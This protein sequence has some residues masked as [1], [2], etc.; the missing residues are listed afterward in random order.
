MFPKRNKKNID[1]EIDEVQNTKEYEV[2]T[3][4][5]G[6][7]ASDF[8]SKIEEQI[9]ILNNFRIKTNDIKKIKITTLE[10]YKPID[11]KS[12]IKKDII[13]TEETKTQI[14][15][16]TG[17]S[18]SSPDDDK[19][20]P[21]LLIVDKTK[22]LKTLQYYRE[23][24]V[25]EIK[26][27]E[28]YYE[29]IKN[30]KFKMNYETGILQDIT[31]NEKNHFQYLGVWSS[32]T[33]SI[34]VGRAF[35]PLLGG[36]LKKFISSLFGTE[37]SMYEFSDKLAKGIPFSNNEFIGGITGINTYVN[38]YFF[39]NATTQALQN[40]NPDYVLRYLAQNGSQKILSMILYNGI[41]FLVG[42]SS[43]PVLLSSV[44]ASTL[45]FL[46][47]IS[48][49]TQSIFVSD[50]AQ[51]GVSMLAQM[52]GTMIIGE[53]MNYRFKELAEYENT[54]KEISKKQLSDKRKRE[55][56]KKMMKFMEEQKHDLI[57]DR[58]IRGEYNLMDKIEEVAKENS[59]LIGFL[60]G[61][62][63]MVLG[64]RQIG[65]FDSEFWNQQVVPS[66]ETIS[67]KLEE[68]LDISGNTFS[69][70]FKAFLIPLV[71]KTLLQQL[72]IREKIQKKV[73][74]II[75]E[76]VIPYLKEFHTI[77][78]ISKWKMFKEI[79]VLRYIL[80]E[81]MKIKSLEYYT[82]EKLFE[83]MTT[84]NITQMVYGEVEK[85]A[86]H[87]I[88][89]IDEDE[90]VGS[91]FGS[92][93]NP[94]T[95]FGATKQDLEG[96]WAEG[97]AS[98]L[99]GASTMI[100]N[101]W[102]NGFNDLDEHT[103]ELGKLKLGVAQF[104]T[105][106]AKFSGTDKELTQQSDLAV[107]QQTAISLWQDGILPT[108]FNL[109]SIKT[110]D[111][112]KNALL[113]KTVSYEQRRKYTYILPLE[114][115][116]IAQVKKLL[117]SYQFLLPEFIKNMIQFQNL[118]ISSEG[119]KRKIN[120]ESLFFGIY[121]ESSLKK[122]YM[123]TDLDSKIQQGKDE[124]QLVNNEYSE[125]L[126][127]IKSWA[128]KLQPFWNN[129][130]NF[131]KNSRVAAAKIKAMDNLKNA[132]DILKKT[133]EPTAIKK[134]EENVR[135]A[136]A[137]MESF[138]DKIYDGTLQ[139]T[140]DD[141]KA[142]QIIWQMSKSILKY[143]LPKSF[144]EIKDFVLNGFY[145][146][147]ILTSLKNMFL[148][149]WRNPSAVK[150]N[151]S[152]QEYLNR[153][154]QVCLKSNLNEYNSCD[155][156]AF[157]KLIQDTKV[158]VINY[159][160]WKKLSDQDKLAFFNTYS[161][162]IQTGDYSFLLTNF[163]EYI[164]PTLL[165]KLIT[166]QNKNIT[167]FPSEAESDQ[168][169]LS[170]YDP[171]SRPVF[172]KA[173]EMGDFSCIGSISSYIDSINDF[174]KNL[175][176][177]G[178]DT[179][180][181]RN[182]MKLYGSVGHKSDPRF[183]SEL[184]EPI[185][186]G[187]KKGNVT[188]VLQSLQ[189]TK[190]FKD[191]DW[192]SI[193]GPQGEEKASLFIE[194]MKY[195]AF[196]HEN[197]LP[198]DLDKLS[199]LSSA[200]KLKAIQLYFKLFNMDKLPEIT[201]NE[202]TSLTEQRTI[203]Q[204]ERN[205]I[206]NQLMGISNGYEALKGVFKENVLLYITQEQ[207]DYDKYY[208][209]FTGT[210][211]KQYKTN[212]NDYRYNGFRK[213][214]E[215]QRDEI[216]RIEKRLNFFAVNYCL[217]NDRDCK[218]NI[219]NPKDISLT[220]HIKLLEKVFDGKLSDNQQK[221]GYIF[222]FRNNK[223]GEKYGVDL[224]KKTTEIINQLDTNGEMNIEQQITYFEKHVGKISSSGK[225]RI[226]YLI[227]LIDTYK[228]K[229]NE[230]VEYLKPFFCTLDNNC[231]QLYDRLNYKFI[232]DIDLNSLITTQLQ[233][234]VSSFERFN[235]VQ[236]DLGTFLLNF[237]GNTIDEL[238]TYEN[239]IA[240][241]N[242]H[243]IEEFQTY[244]QYK[245]LNG[246]DPE[247]IIAT[248]IGKIL[249]FKNKKIE[250]L[251]STLNTLK[252][253]SE[254]TPE[255]LQQIKILETEI[256]NIT[257]ESGLKDLT[258]KLKLLNDKRNYLKNK[259][260]LNDEDNKRL[261]ELDIQVNTIYNEI[262][263]KFGSA[264]KIIKSP[265]IGEKI[266][267]RF[268]YTFEGFVI[269][270]TDEG[271]T[272]ETP[273]IADILSI[274]DQEAS[275]QNIMKDWDITSIDLPDN[276]D[277]LPIS[278]KMTIISNILIEKN[279]FISNLPN[280]IIPCL[281]NTSCQPEL[282]L[283]NKKH[284]VYP[285]NGS[286]YKQ[287]MT[288]L[289]TLYTDFRLESDSATPANLDKEMRE[290]YGPEIEILILK[291]K[292]SINK[293]DALLY[294]KRCD[295]DYTGNTVD[296]LAVLKAYDSMMI[297]L[298]K[299]YDDIPSKY[300]NSFSKE[301][302][303]KPFNN[304]KPYDFK[305]T[306]SKLKERVITYND[307]CSFLVGK[308]VQIECK[309]DNEIEVLNLYEKTTQEID[310]LITG[311]VSTES[312]IGSIKTEVKTLKLQELK[313]IFTKRQNELDSNSI[314][315][316]KLIF[317][318]EITLLPS[319]IT[320]TDKLHFLRQQYETTA[321]DI[322]SLEEKLETSSIYREKLKENE[323]FITVK[324]KK[325]KLQLLWTEMTT[326]AI[327]YGY[328]GN[329][330]S[331]NGAEYDKIFK[332]YQNSFIDKMIL[333][334]ENGYQQDINK[335]LINSGNIS[336]TSI[337][338]II[339]YLK[340]IKDSKDI[341]SLK[342]LSFNQI[343]DAE[344]KLKTI[345]ELKSLVK[346]NFKYNSTGNLDEDLEHL[347]Q[348]ETLMNEKI[349]EWT[350]KWA[351]SS[352]EIENKTL[353]E[354]YTYLQNI[355]T[356]NTLTIT[357]IND[358]G[359]FKNKFE[360]NND[361][362]TEIK[363]LF[364]DERFTS[365]NGS[366]EQLLKENNFPIPAIEFLITRIKQY[367]EFSKK[368]PYKKTIIEYENFEKEMLY[369]V[370]KVYKLLNGQS[371]YEKGTIE[372]ENKFYKIADID[373]KFQTELQKSIKNI[374]TL[375]N[376]LSI[377]FRINIDESKLNDFDYLQ[378]LSNTLDNIEKHQ[379]SVQ[380][381]LIRQINTLG[382]KGTTEQQLCKSA[383]DIENCLNQLLE[384]SKDVW[385]HKL[386]KIKK[387]Y[388]YKLNVDEKINLIL[389][390]LP[391]SATK[392]VDDFNKRYT[393]YEKIQSE[394]INKIQDLN[395][396]I[397]NK[398]SLD[399]LTN[400]SEIEL[401]KHIDQLT[402]TVEEKNER[403][404][405]LIFNIGLPNILEESDY[406]NKTFN[407]KI[408][409]LETKQKEYEIIVKQK[410]EIFNGHQIYDTF[411][412]QKLNLIQSIKFLDDIFIEQ[413]VLYKKIT[414]GKKLLPNINIAEQFEIVSYQYSPETIELLKQL[415]G[416]KQCYKVETLQFNG[417]NLNFLTIDETVEKYI[418][419]NPFDGH[420]TPINDLIKIKLDQLKP[421]FQDYKKYV[422]YIRNKKPDGFSIGSDE[423]ILYNGKKISNYELLTG[424]LS[425]DNQWEMGI[426]Q[427]L[428]G[429]IRK[430]IQEVNDK[431]SNE[432]KQHFNALAENKIAIEQLDIIEDI[433]KIEL[434]LASTIKEQ[435]DKEGGSFLIRGIQ[436][437]SSDFDTTRT[438]YN[439]DIVSM[440]FK[441]YR[442]L[443]QTISSEF[444]DNPKILKIVN[445]CDDYNINKCINL[446]AL[447]WFLKNLEKGQDISSYFNRLHFFETINY[448]FD[449]EFFMMTIHDQNTILKDMMK[450]IET[451]NKPLFDIGNTN[452]YESFMLHIDKMTGEHTEKE[453]DE[454]VN[455]IK[456]S[457]TDLDNRDSLD[458]A[459]SKIE[460]S[461][462][463][464]TTKR[465]AKYNL[466]IFFQQYVYFQSISGSSR[467]IKLNELNE[468]L[469]T[470]LNL[471]MEL[472]ERYDNAEKK[473]A[474]GSS[475]DKQIGDLEIKEIEHTRKT[476]SM[477]FIEQQ[478]LYLSNEF[479]NILSSNNQTDLDA[480]LE[481]LHL[482]DTRISIDDPENGM[483][484]KD[485]SIS[486]FINF[487]KLNGWSQE[488]I[489]EKLINVVMY[490]PLK[491]NVNYFIPPNESNLK[492]AF[493][494]QIQ[495]LVHNAYKKTLL[496]R[497]GGKEDISDF[498]MKQ[499][500]IDELQKSKLNETDLKN[501][502]TI[503]KSITSE[504]WNQQDIENIVSDV[505]KCLDSGKN[506]CLSKQ[507]LFNNSKF[508][509]FSE[510]Y[511][512]GYELIVKQFSNTKND[513]LKLRTDIAEAIN[514]AVDNLS[515]TNDKI[516]AQLQ[517]SAMKERLKELDELIILFGNN[518]S[519]WFKDL[520][521]LF[522]KD[523]SEKNIKTFFGALNKDLLTKYNGLFDTFINIF[524]RQRMGLEILTSLGKQEQT[525]NIP[526]PQDNRSIIVEVNEFTD[527]LF[528]RAA[529]LE[530][531]AK[532]TPP[533]QSSEANEALEKAKELKSEA[534]EM[535]KLA[536]A[537]TRAND[538]LSSSENNLSDKQRIL[539]EL[540]QNNASDEQI[541]KAEADV[542]KAK[543]SV[544]KAADDFGYYKNS[545]DK[546]KNRIYP[547]KDLDEFKKKYPFIFQSKNIGILFDKKIQD[548]ILN[549][550]D[551]KQRKSAEMFFKRYF[552]KD[553]VIN[554]EELKN[555]VATESL[556]DSTIE[557][558][559]SITETT[560]K[561][562]NR[563]MIDVLI[564]QIE[565][566][567]GRT[568]SREE[569]DRLYKH[570]E[571]EQLK[572]ETKFKNILMETYVECLVEP[573][574]TD[575]FIPTVQAI[576]LQTATRGLMELFKN[577][578][579]SNFASLG[580]LSKAFQHVS[581]VSSTYK[582]L[583]GEKIPEKTPEKKTLV[584]IVD[585]D[586]ART[587]SGETHY[588]Y[589]WMTPKQQRAAGIETDIKNFRENGKYI[590][591]I[592]KKGKS[593]VPKEQP[594]KQPVPKEQPAKQDV[595]KE[596]P[597]KQD[598]PKGKT[599]TPEIVD[600]E[601]KKFERT[602]SEQKHVVF[603]PKENFRNFVKGVKDS[604]N[605]LNIFPKKQTLKT[606]KPFEQEQISKLEEKKGKIDIKFQKKDEIIQEKSAS[607]N[608]EN[609]KN[610]EKIEGFDFTEYSNRLLNYYHSTRVYTYIHKPIES[611]YQH[612]I[613]LKNWRPIGVRDFFTNWRT[614][615]MVSLEIL[616]GIYKGMTWL[617]SKF[618][619]F[620]NALG[621]LTT[622]F[623]KS[624]ATWVEDAAK[625][626]I[627]QISIT[628][629]DGEEQAIAGFGMIFA[630]AN[631]IVSKITEAGGKKIDKF[632][633][634]VGNFVKQ[635]TRNFV[636]DIAEDKILGKDKSGW[637]RW[638][639]DMVKS[640]VLKI[641]GS[642]N[643]LS[644]KL[645]EIENFIGKKSA[646]LWNQF[647]GINLT[648]SVGKMLS[649]IIGTIP[650]NLQDTNPTDE[651]KEQVGK[652]FE[653]AGKIITPF[654]DA[655]QGILKPGGISRFVYVM[656]QN[657]E[658]YEKYIV[659]G[660][661]DLSETANWIRRGILTL[662]GPMVMRLAIIS[663][664]AVSMVMNIGQI[665]KSFITNGI[666]LI[667]GMFEQ[668]MS[669]G[670]V[671]NPSNSLPHP[672]EGSQTQFH[673]NPSSETTPLS[674]NGIRKMFSAISNLTNDF[675]K[676]FYNVFE[677]LKV[678]VLR[679]VDI[680]VSNDWWGIG[681]VKNKLIGLAVPRNFDS[682]QLN[683]YNYLAAG[684][685]LYPK[686]ILN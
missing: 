274:K 490:I 186:I 136:Q 56:F 43:M 414:N 360:E 426:F 634:Y 645:D 570:I 183:L 170:F 94:A 394:L 1:N 221:P 389:T 675:F 207:P 588:S 150:L 643:Y 102:V 165:N 205:Q 621:D 74:E 192:N 125:S 335:I 529:G 254:N 559:I 664:L 313:D 417:K 612:I 464:N 241:F 60:L 548:S 117:N 195:H 215:K 40:G 454:F 430:T 38:I 376:K 208:N 155:V 356:E 134:A 568:L 267:S 223:K 53:F 381:E 631:K 666:D 126:K 400:L 395:T 647:V 606:D 330:K 684:S 443:I 440:F 16:I 655:I 584:R 605:P 482:N 73:N 6:I 153:M 532:T 577:L 384:T 32:V 336:E 101:H 91:V 445:A 405:Q 581:V 319:L 27:V 652:A 461:N 561:V 316:D 659:F 397:G 501:F 562:M 619:K 252:S 358:L 265:E 648:A 260:P 589:I 80:I 21:D 171:F 398:F 236:N 428:D 175:T 636:F 209:F 189:N 492:D 202:A 451:T 457:I 109:E 184:G 429:S 632:A 22:S 374:N 471:E 297:D 567:G 142:H 373:T 437:K 622:E 599:S 154:Y 90:N 678:G 611:G 382:I 247:K 448:Q 130:N 616:G 479:N 404:N 531:S 607:V 359:F 481:K 284:I 499:K 624:M 593:T 528:R 580:A 602:S 219:L 453:F 521:G 551:E 124:L 682:D 576:T 478:L 49:I 99:K 139:M 455:N 149:F 677:V 558:I 590:V 646:S 280:F 660:R 476:Q 119:R 286:S 579:V 55:S 283:D 672:P 174:F 467:E 287:I 343:M 519:G 446:H 271:T 224:S 456:S 514:S 459:F 362:L 470:F 71:Q 220:E 487:T 657:K 50:K 608:F 539:D 523:F 667:K 534:Y 158:P 19:D 564:R 308:G 132:Q 569:K 524:S 281:L 116:S 352:H 36:G 70:Q 299:E 129:F 497:K 46:S 542:S 434:H 353:T 518:E 378:T 298:K 203:R 480:F 210:F 594:A 33:G 530:N 375:N 309:Q 409:F 169:K 41:P 349:N 83:S 201:E 488:D 346:N 511:L 363:S 637:M 118:N 468:V 122:Y 535:G 146:D 553:K 345:I 639:F 92:L 243:S 601:G 212:G 527:D 63:G 505:N 68:T 613:G 317:Q 340:S 218:N 5:L 323:P 630:G 97:S 47:P 177:T 610:A 661:Q 253:K 39:L 238:N 533:E 635:K 477:R 44:A 338:N 103:K 217:E 370:S 575:C 302:L 211:F 52:G 686:L 609:D 216:K 372:F 135:I 447:N 676:S 463:S 496:S 168:D 93:I 473:L 600:I 162:F 495:D 303:S 432:K 222:M 188:Y 549:K 4:A 670:A 167:I 436:F 78:K 629:S 249:L 393:D 371:I 261:K 449:E 137:E 680:T 598:V 416:T 674:L 399:S 515:N 516:T 673:Q 326:D 512:K 51:M 591:K 173:S 58:L 504:D 552:Q 379:E 361:G 627:S 26:Q 77:E 110:V 113:D 368:Y 498:D 331:F 25:N 681:W 42:I 123:G 332:T 54:Q 176:G 583:A 347:K 66:A 662:L 314:E 37:G 587:R 407:Q 396:K 85:V 334:A 7:D 145:L 248:K 8:N 264:I 387:F 289:K 240:N 315:I 342:N 312:I 98:G 190:D 81:K 131:V 259:D 412:D 350:E 185:T 435:I 421:F 441:N 380:Q 160:N 204:N 245:S 546:S 351:I 550:L 383:T 121:P 469:D 566:N 322:T 653:K 506:D 3:N 578:A 633:D 133:Y 571:S 82:V 603:N 450:I 325:T 665:M 307:K 402:K 244:I 226:D 157:E 520:A 62:V 596:Q 341:H 510:I 327:K 423:S 255:E 206:M 59:G 88:Q 649:D 263:S 390:S 181:T 138:K 595:P 366:A 536:R 200:D 385:K 329:L 250:E 147:T 565:I 277:K 355:N 433:A 272:S 199:K 288:R 279:N 663:D 235:L 166:L 537:L 543:E 64:L 79:Q 544:D 658:S 194:Y 458:K 427:L 96:H 620:T 442:Q 656:L 84:N 574:G 270:N 401:N 626:L 388:N 266:I 310:R 242:G 291:K 198:F 413:S 406:L 679:W 438:D 538:N 151:M 48:A 159:S 213:M 225:K 285:L 23:I 517:I 582:E 89:Y 324:Q 337:P 641:V 57:T 431:L 604:L 2:I 262:I 348:Y 11:H 114:S 615:P 318:L 439:P 290:I 28:F 292:Y 161:T 156:F 418:Y 141:L 306:L 31:G 232:K 354:K 391:N 554:W 35:L 214:I 115:L 120:F 651:E 403:I 20:T 296:E 128:P 14:S 127:S 484:N 474:S 410:L 295:W 100:N 685:Y 86:T 585:K 144:F 276:F 640:G 29:K 234:D 472:G 301:I 462:L 420:F 10:T 230:A 452:Q 466:Y 563:S 61:S 623:V 386:E 246:S 502:L 106:M 75:R 9:N 618:S 573:N 148:D 367:D 233:S 275:I 67:A 34:L 424:K 172:K 483:K 17:A 654:I 557:T 182:T 507:Y 526:S 597:A 152:A 328:K 508:V 411:K 365:T 197:D 278:Q 69:D 164:D 644:D 628:G 465:Q 193:S 229:R 15:M 304:Y 494:N 178:Y 256:T 321:K 422:A 444:K 669:I 525:I 545:F 486:E 163:K 311:I 364:F 179:E 344:T 231:D 650:Q 294:L 111:D 300:P 104:Q 560:N 408:E 339:P 87:G 671:F 592:D 257:S 625:L 668:I 503:S 493:K 196:I 522:S 239:L 65:L 258:N 556:T 614:V 305:K 392:M 12:V 143:H 425:K 369:K 107:L 419:S 227:D 282:F 191:V 547:P 112:L 187:E 555:Q 320:Q 377:K 572:D 105:F 273:S 180:F 491:N 460:N 293:E 617:N 415:C 251:L 586:A 95:Y 357:K 13:Q 333:L 30:K 140:P 24:D 509:N 108:D 72:E 228:Q 540:K 500:S 76:K 268:Q 638:S 269:V 513:I 18:G 489:I 475:E 45:P 683:K 541:K 642:V 237:R 485:L